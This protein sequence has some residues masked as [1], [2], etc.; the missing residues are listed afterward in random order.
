MINR[1]LIV[2]LGSIG[3]RHL[4]LA[5]SLLPYADI[6]ALRRQATSEIPE[7]AN[8][9]FSSLDEAISFAPQIAVIANPAPFHIFSAQNLAEVG[10]HLLIEKPL[11]DSTNGVLQ[12]INTCD[13]QD[14]LLMVGYNLRFLT[15]LLHFREKLK[16]SVIGKVLSVR[17]EVGQY[18]PSWRP[19]IDYRN[20]V[21]AQHDKP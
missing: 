9:C 3:Q 8:G 5:R 20:S 14:T 4:R 11:S 13:K 15:S 10:A 7:Y 12:L 6:R 18:L 2:G 21:S 17:C 19:N 16:D 1:V